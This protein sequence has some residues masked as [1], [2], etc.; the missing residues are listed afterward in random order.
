MGK[1]IFGFFS[2]RLVPVAM[3]LAGRYLG[4][5]VHPRSWTFG[6]K[7]KVI[8]QTDLPHWG[9]RAWGPTRNSFFPPKI[10]EAEPIR[11]HFGS[12]IGGAYARP[13]SYPPAIPRRLALHCPRCR[14]IVPKRLMGSG[15]GPEWCRG[16]AANSPSRAPSGDPTP[17]TLSV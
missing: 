6:P 14:P 1:A 7:F 3:G 11:V 10:S 4:Q 2:G 9:L 8:A 16:A 15:N 12:L 5:Q 17:I 13:R